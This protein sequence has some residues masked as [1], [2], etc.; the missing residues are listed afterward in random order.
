MMIDGH[1]LLDN[2]IQSSWTH[3]EPHVRFSVHV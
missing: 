2:Y 3:G 1:L